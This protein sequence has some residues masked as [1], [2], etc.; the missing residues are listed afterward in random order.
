MELLYTLEDIDKVAARVLAFAKTK[1]IVLDAP[2][3][4]GKTTLITAMCKQLGVTDPIS[5]PTFSIVNE[6]QGITSTVLHFDLYR[7]KDRSELLDIG[8]EDY[9]YRRNAYIFI[10]WP[11]ISLDLIDE[12]HLLRIF[13]HD[14]VTRKLIFS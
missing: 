4:S 9:L 7:L 1:I 14:N 3:G 10:E 6:Y 5:S 12:Y 11:E 2:M 8:F 13:H